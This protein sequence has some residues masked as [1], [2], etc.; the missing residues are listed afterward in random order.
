MQTEL[1]P[2]SIPAATFVDRRQ[3]ESDSANGSYERRQFA[4]GHSDLSDEAR[5]L[6]EAIDQ[7][8]FR[9]RRRFISYE[10]ILSVVKSLGY[11]RV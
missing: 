4:D 1:Q 9:H 2:I 8:K 11:E 3:G 7:Y 5:E 10:E 6:G